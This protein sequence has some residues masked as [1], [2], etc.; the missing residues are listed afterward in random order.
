[1]DIFTVHKTTANS[2]LILQMAGGVAGDPFRASVSVN[3]GALS[4]GG[5]AFA[6]NSS[7]GLT[8]N[9]WYHVAGVFLSNTRR[10]CFVDGVSGNADTSVRAAF[11]G[12]DWTLVG[13]GRT[14]LGGGF[15]SQR[16]FNGKIAEAAVWNVQLTNEEIMSLAKG[17]CPTQVRPQSLEFYAPLVNK[18]QE[19]MYDRGFSGV[20]AGL[21]PAVFEHTRIFR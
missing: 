21:I 14:T 15:A 11:T 5:T 17:A 4:A 2:K 12:P 8:S 6:G 20:G 1:M 18:T 16:R 19:L 13:A 7:T 9:K 10:W 3:S